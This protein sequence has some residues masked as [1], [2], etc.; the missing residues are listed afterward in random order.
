M[1]THKI[2]HFV[3][4]CE[5]NFSKMWMDICITF[6]I[7]VDSR[8]VSFCVR[9]DVGLFRD[10]STLSFSRSLSGLFLFI[11][12]MSGRRPLFAT[13]VKCFFKA[14]KASLRPLYVYVL[15]E[16]LSFSRLSRPRAP[17]QTLTLNTEK[18]QGWMSWCC[19]ICINFMKF[20]VIQKRIKFWKIIP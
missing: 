16:N 18:K 2:F 10:K 1:W 4:L 11:L 9:L 3:S 8:T 20:T 5:S 17:H 7:C 6:K 12:C 13:S 19:S 14:S 15:V